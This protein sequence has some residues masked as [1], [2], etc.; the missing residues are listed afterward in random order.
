MTLDH[1][2]FDAIR[3][4][5][6][7]HQ[8]SMF[9]FR[10]EDGIPTPSWSMRSVNPIDYGCHAGVYH[11]DFRIRY[12]SSCVGIDNGEEDDLKL[13]FMDGWLVC[14]SHFL[15][16]WLA[17]RGSLAGVPRKCDGVLLMVEVAGSPSIHR[18]RLDENLRMVFS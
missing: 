18:N 8:G 13:Y 6:N 14:Y 11:L 12:E 3:N 17:R 4:D 2:S 1:S 16:S 7:R 15:D 9:L 10:H 5:I